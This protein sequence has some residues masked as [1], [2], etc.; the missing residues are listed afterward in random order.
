MFD[1]STP[2][3]EAMPAI[4]KLFKRHEQSILEHEH[5][6]D[7]DVK[8]ICLQIYAQTIMK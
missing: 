1:K 2:V 4:N 6:T 8:P 5:Y 7:F 3:A